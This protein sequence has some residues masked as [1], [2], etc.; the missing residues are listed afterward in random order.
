[1]WEKFSP[2]ILE[3]QLISEVSNLELKTK[4]VLLQY[5]FPKGF[6]FL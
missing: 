3:F 1:M 4:E 6:E 5:I 2:C